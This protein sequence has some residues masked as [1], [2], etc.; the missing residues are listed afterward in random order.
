VRH[1]PDGEII[2]TIPVETIRQ[3][4]SFCGVCGL[5]DHEN[6]MLL[7]EGCN[8]ACH[9]T[10]LDPPLDVVPVQLWLCPYCIYRIFVFIAQEVSVEIRRS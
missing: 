5:P 10:C 8:F 7:C 1:H 3:E 9:L 6:R 4:L 2:K